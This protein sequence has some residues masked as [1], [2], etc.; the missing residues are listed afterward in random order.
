MSRDHRKLRVFTLADDLVIAVYE[1]SAGF[2]SAE[3]FGLQAQIRRAAISVAS[4]IVEGSA[5][6]STREYLNFVNITAGSASEVRYL[7][8][9]SHRLGFMTADAQQT[10]SA[11]Y[12]EL[13]ARLQ[14]LLKALSPEP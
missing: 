6:R 11:R 13:V 4:N 3:R 10:I 2:P 7:A 9:L 12:T 14:A 8:D 1:A 5:R